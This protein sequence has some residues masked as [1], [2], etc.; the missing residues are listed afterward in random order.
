DEEAVHGAEREPF[1]RAV[2]AQQPLELRR[3]EVRVGNEACLAAD[4]LRVELA[5][6]VRRAP[7]LP[8]DRRRDGPAG[9]AVPEDR[10]LALVRDRDH[11]RLA[12]GVASSVG[13]GRP[14]LVRVVLDP[15]RPR[16]VLRELAITTADDA[17]VVVERQAGRT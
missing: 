12:A 16:E 11:R 2:L 7:V 3:R 15:A 6:A 9:L 17:E 8:D 13:D 10:R 1:A 5:A 14:D 4:E